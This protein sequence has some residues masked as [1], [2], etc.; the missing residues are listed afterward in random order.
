MLLLRGRV[1]E[2]KQDGA[3]EKARRHV[4]QVR[5]EC[6]LQVRASF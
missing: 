2:K 1:C 3:G 5:C 6:V 4:N